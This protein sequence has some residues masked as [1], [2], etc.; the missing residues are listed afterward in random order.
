MSTSN[1]QPPQSAEAEF[2]PALSLIPIEEEAAASED[3]EKRTLEG[4]SVLL[5]ED[6]VLL[7]VLGTKILKGLGATVSVVNNGVQAVEAMTSMIA[8]EK[9]KREAEAA[10]VQ[11]GSILETSVFPHY[12]LILMDCKV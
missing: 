10:N 3:E 9:A 5:V 2:H 12:D 7:Q 4:L 6:Q 1:E 11:E 8:G